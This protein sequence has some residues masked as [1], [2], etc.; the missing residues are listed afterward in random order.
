M[1]KIYIL[2]KPFNAS[3][4]KMMLTESMY[5]VLPGIKKLLYHELK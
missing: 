3:G 1:E 4:E 5:S 2:I